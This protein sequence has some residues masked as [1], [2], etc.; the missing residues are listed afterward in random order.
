MRLDV[1][2]RDAATGGAG[3]SLTAATRDDGRMFLLVAPLPLR[4]GVPPG[5]VL[6]AISQ[7]G[8]RHLAGADTLRRMFGLTAAEARLASALASGKTIPE[9]IV[10]WE[11]SENTLRSQLSAIFAKTGTAGQRGLVALI[12][13]IPVRNGGS[14]PGG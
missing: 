12:E 13:A 3:G 1:L 11:L 4:F 9:L 2:V 5:H 7:P 8:A 10:A 6:V 14:Q